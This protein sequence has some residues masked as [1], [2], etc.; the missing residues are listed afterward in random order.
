MYLGVSQKSQHPAM[1]YAAN[2]H[3]HACISI[4]GL[5]HLHDVCISINGLLH[6]HDACRI[7]YERRDLTSIY[8]MYVIRITDLPMPCILVYRRKASIQLCFMQ[9]MDI[10]IQNTQIWPNIDMII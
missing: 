9:L 3:S 8:M 4:N 6:L 10:I 1:F 5:L 7:Q 2:G